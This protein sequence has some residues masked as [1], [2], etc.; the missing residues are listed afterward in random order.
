MGWDEDQN[1]GERSAL[2]AKNMRG[3]WGIFRVI[4]SHKNESDSC[5]MI[6]GYVTQFKS[7]LA[8]QSNGW[9]CTSLG[10]IV[11]QF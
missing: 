3:K 5:I 4:M 9:S 7:S 2:R 11:A 10:G 6:G 8:S 1:E